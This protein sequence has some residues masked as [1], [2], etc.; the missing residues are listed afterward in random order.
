MNLT[1]SDRIQIIKLGWRNIGMF[2]QNLHLTQT[3]QEV[4]IFVW[5]ESF[6]MV[7]TSGQAKCRTNNILVILWTIWNFQGDLIWMVLYKNLFLWKSIMINYHR[8]LPK[9]WWRKNQNRAY[10]YLIEPKREIIN[11]WSLAKCIFLCGQLGQLWY[12]NN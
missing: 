9:K 4:V 12:L 7:A 3:I 11:G 10:K 8:N 1:N 6:K 2:S 5:I